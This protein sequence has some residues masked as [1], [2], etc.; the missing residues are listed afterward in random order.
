ML[1]LKGI[2]KAF[3]GIVV[4]ND[5]D[6]TLS[7]GEALGVIGP[8]GA[9]KSTLFNLITG[10]LRPDRG[11]IILEGNDITW[12]KPEARCHAGLGRSFQIPLPFSY[13]TVFENLSV[14]AL[15]GARVSEA[16]AVQLCGD[17]LAL[18][19]L[20][21]KANVLAGS[22]PLLDRKRLEL[23]RAL[24]TRPRI[25]LLDEIAGGL[26]DVECHLLVEI[27][28]R[29]RIDGVAIIWIEHVVH[30]LLAVVDRLIALDFGKIAMQGPP[31]E[32]MRS[33]EVQAIY[34]GV[35]A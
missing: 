35:P 12:T 9:G 11:R 13:L 16:E 26:T 19:G 15:F 14:A 33:K 22:L 24:A 30:A 10:M 5:I 4:A 3:G 29:I 20:E 1:E 8:N 27:I 23:A 25:L 18:T 34:M 28:R 32:V 2:S 6:L 31:L 7:R 17:I 21:S